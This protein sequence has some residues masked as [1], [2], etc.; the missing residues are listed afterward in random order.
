MNK[1]EINDFKKFWAPEITKINKTYY[2]ITFLSKEKINEMTPL[3]IE[4]KPDSVIRILM[5]YKG[6]ISYKN[7]KELKIEIPE[8]KGFVVVE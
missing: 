8:R 7:V 5:D 6:L 2:F 1:K 3:T 4:S